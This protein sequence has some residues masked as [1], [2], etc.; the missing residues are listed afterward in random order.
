METPT[1]QATPKIFSPTL[2]RWAGYGLLVLTTLDLG[3]ILL[4]PRLMDPAWEFQTM[5]AVIERVPVPLLALVLIFFGENYARNKIE[6][7]VLKVLSWATL[8][9]GIFLLLL[10]PL[11]IVNTIRINNTNTE[12][13]TAQ[14]TQQTQQL[15]QFEQRLNQATPE[16][17][18][19]F[20]QS[21]QIELDSANQQPPKEQIMAQL[22]QVK[23]RLQTEFETQQ[24]S[25]RNT[26]FESAIK[27]NLSA[28]VS[29]A[30]FIYAW[31]LTGWARGGKRK[32]SKTSKKVAPQA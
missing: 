32:R 19:A 22:T 10:M 9:F 25:Q 6:R 27:W 28:L 3:A 5:G 12:Q 8:A 18:Q 1:P 17:I 14:F 21:Q 26:L 23:Q 4:P 11:G 31:R 15:V 16:Q 2:M 29:G 20:L 24:T 13:L 7:N 30:L